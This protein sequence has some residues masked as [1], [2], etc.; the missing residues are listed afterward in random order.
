MEASSTRP[1]ARAG[2]VTCWQ[3]NSL[4]RLQPHLTSRYTAPLVV[5][6]ALASAAL[7]LG[8]VPISNHLRLPTLG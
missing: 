7:S 4:G 6:S 3:Q 1:C 2:G 8:T 5:S